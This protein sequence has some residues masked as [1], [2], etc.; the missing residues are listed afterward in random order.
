M[1]APLLLRVVSSAVLVLLLT[2]TTLNGPLPNLAH[3]ASMNVH[4]VVGMKALKYYGTILSGYNGTTEAQARDF[5]AAITSNPEAVLAG[6]DFPDFM[7]ACNTKN[8]DHQDEGEIAHWPPFHA[9]AV[10]YVRD[11]PDFQAWL[12]NGTAWSA[13]TAKLVAFCFGLTVHYV[14]DEM[15]EGLRHPLSFGRGFTELLAWTNEGAAGIGNAAET[16]ANMGADFYTAWALN[17]SSIGVWDRYFPLKDIAVIYTRTPKLHGDG[18][19][20]DVT[21]GALEYCNA[22]FDLGLWALKNLGPLAFQA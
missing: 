12:A 16:P 17:E 14:T 4:S 11:R 21:L 22:I 8:A 19:Y 1:S 10:G 15:W 18:N 7:Y 3:G 5:N 6:S 2:M 13:D 20:T 9:A